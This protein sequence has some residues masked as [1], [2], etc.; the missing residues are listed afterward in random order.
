MRT[1]GTQ[2]RA[3]SLLPRWLQ[4]EK[5]ISGL[6]SP[7]LQSSP[8]SSEYPSSV[9][10]SGS[11]LRSP[12]GPADDETQWSR[13]CPSATCSVVM[14]GLL[15]LTLDLTCKYHCHKDGESQMDS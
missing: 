12:L 7:P 2:T 1:A 4:E 3:P 10:A 11:P 6:H 13:K 9:P 8:H 14:S 5:A 15:V